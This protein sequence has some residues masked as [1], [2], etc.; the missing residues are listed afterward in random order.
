MVPYHFQMSDF[1]QA[2]DVIT[3]LLPQ[4]KSFTGARRREYFTTLLEP[5]F[6]SVEN[7]HDFYNEL[8][9][10]TRQKVIEVG[11][12]KDAFFLPALKGPANVRQLAAL[13]KMMAAYARK[14]RKD[15]RIRD[16]IR[17]DA[18][19]ILTMVSRTEERRF[20]TAVGDYFL[21]DHTVPMTETQ[22]A[23]QVAA[24]LER[25]GDSYW[26]TPSSQVY[27][28]I[29]D[30]DELTEVVAKL[31]HARNDLNQRYMNVRTSFKNVQHAVL[32]K[33]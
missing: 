22:R 14:R 2:I 9:L 8:F 4:L 25:S 16:G 15:E 19:Q 12:G 3:K 5:L 30:L 29:C 32:S 10:E 28:A 24:L 11:W 27:L 31:D 33:T 1:V 6:A 20:L 21:G 7:A 18:R 13:D 23:Y 17:Q 26:R